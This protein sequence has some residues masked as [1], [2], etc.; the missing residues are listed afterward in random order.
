M[1]TAAW[2][3]ASRA[4]TARAPGAPAAS[5]SR[6]GE[7]ARRAA[8]RLDHARPLEATAGAVAARVHLGELGAEEEDLRRVVDPEEHQ[9]ERPRRAVDRRRSRAAEVEADD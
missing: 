5:S 9:H 4:P 3:S 2:A 8:G 6:L 1:R 7:S